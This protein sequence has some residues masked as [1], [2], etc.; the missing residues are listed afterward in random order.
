MHN[1]RYKNLY[2]IKA[3][4]Y[5]I[6]NSDFPPQNCTLAEI[7]IERRPKKKCQNLS[8]STLK[9]KSDYLIDI[10]FAVCHF[11]E[12]RPGNPR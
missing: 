2:I 12:R 7:S 3:Y 8:N 1:T 5:C 10:L 11:L 6:V 4:P 9:N